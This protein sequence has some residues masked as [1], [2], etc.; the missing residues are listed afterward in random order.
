MGYRTASTPN[1]AEQKKIF[2]GNHTYGWSN[3]WLSGRRT[4]CIC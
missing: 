4:E 1:L 2:V 3:T